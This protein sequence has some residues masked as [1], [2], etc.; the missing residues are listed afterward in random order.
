MLH[1]TPSRNTLHHVS[2]SADA[3]GAGR[4]VL[5]VKFGMGMVHFGDAPRGGGDSGES[6][7][8]W[9]REATDGRRPCVYVLDFLRPQF[10]YKADRSIHF[11]IRTWPKSMVAIVSYLE[12]ISNFVEIIKHGR[13][14]GDL[15]KNTYPV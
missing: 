10:S 3:E 13:K 6:G 2:K 15:E 11:N 14:M 1:G 8:G 5:R 4:K 12:E 7:R 9:L